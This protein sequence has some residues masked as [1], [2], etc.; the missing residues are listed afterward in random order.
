VWVPDNHFNKDVAIPA[1]AKIE[2]PDVCRDPG[3][4]RLSSI[5]DELL[6]LD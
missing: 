5:V 6:I 4:T 1:S 2:L 3:A